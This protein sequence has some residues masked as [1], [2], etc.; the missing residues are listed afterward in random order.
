MSKSQMRGWKELLKLSP[1][2]HILNTKM[3]VTIDTTTIFV[4]ID[5]VAIVR[6]L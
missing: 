4:P 1:V 5:S 6:T 3:C 2:Y